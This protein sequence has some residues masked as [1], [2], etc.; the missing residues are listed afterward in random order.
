[1][2]FIA[3]DAFGVGDGFIDGD[4]FGVGED[5]AADDGPLTGTVA[6]P[7]N[8]HCSLRRTKVSTERYSPLM[9][10][11]LPSGVLYL[12]PLTTLRA[13]AIAE[14]LSRTLIAISDTSHESADKAP[15]SMSLRSWSFPPDVP[16]G[17]KI[18]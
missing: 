17:Y 14:S 8:C 7:I 10:A 9:S 18:T 13:V 3:G 5:I 11:V 16:S 12:P 2:V 1:M 4:A 15:D 6:D